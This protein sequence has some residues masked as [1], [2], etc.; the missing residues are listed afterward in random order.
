MN[1]PWTGAH[2]G[3]RDPFTAYVCDDLTLEVVRTV[4]DEMGW[5]Q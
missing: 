3:T 4:C 1:A 2:A 5:P